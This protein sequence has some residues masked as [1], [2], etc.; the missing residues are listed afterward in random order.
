M[1]N[2]PYPKRGL[3]FSILNA[4]KGI[5]SKPS[6]FTHKTMTTIASNDSG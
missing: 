5:N 2:F 1:G 6:I 3:Y 4:S